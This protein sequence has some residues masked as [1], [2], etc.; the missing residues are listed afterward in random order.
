MKRTENKSS[1]VVSPFVPGPQDGDTV[2]GP[3]KYDVETGL[4]MGTPTIMVSFR[5]Y[6]LT[7]ESSKSRPH[8]SI[9]D[10]ISKILSFPKLFL[11]FYKTKHELHQY[12]QNRENMA[13][14][15]LT[16][17][18]AWNVSNPS[19]ILDALE[20]VKRNTADSKVH[21]AYGQTM[22]FSSVNTQVAGGYKSTVSGHRSDHTAILEE[23]A[24][25]KVG[26]VSKPEIEQTIS[27]HL[28][29]YYAGQK[30]SAVIDWFGGSGIVLLFVT[31]GK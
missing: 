3:T 11:E 7:L 25:K 24:R 8:S 2:F 27:S 17:R 4:T 19:E 10:E 1:S 30:W 20:N 13:G 29:E 18:T 9:D 31:A 5:A 21:R 22:L 26:A 12:L 28:H 16:A 15:R 14:E 23:L 6:F